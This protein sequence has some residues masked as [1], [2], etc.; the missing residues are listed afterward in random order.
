MMMASKQPHT[1]CRQPSIYAIV[2]EYLS[3]WFAVQWQHT[4]TKC[5]CTVHSWLVM[6]FLLQ[7]LSMKG[8]LVGIGGSALSSVGWLAL[9]RDTHDILFRSTLG[10]TVVYNAHPH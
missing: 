4:A 1:P 10:F 9:S 3:R 5:N 6:A 8:E 2:F 7:G